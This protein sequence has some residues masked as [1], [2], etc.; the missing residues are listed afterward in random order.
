MQGVLYEFNLLRKSLL[1]HDIS[2]RHREFLM[3]N[4]LN[5]PL[6]SIEHVY[7]KRN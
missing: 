4:F 5:T 2:E 6:A 7:N 3:Q 1:L